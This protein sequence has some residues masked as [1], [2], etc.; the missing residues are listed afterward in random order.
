MHAKQNT[1]RYLV[2]LPEPVGK[3]NGIIGG[4]PYVP[5]GL[6]DKTGILIV[7]EKVFKPGTIKAPAKSQ[8]IGPPLG[9]TPVRWL[10][11]SWSGSPVFGSP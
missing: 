11:R 7:P 6:P 9:T 2:Q 3:N 10:A 1:P 5:G 4:H 8:L